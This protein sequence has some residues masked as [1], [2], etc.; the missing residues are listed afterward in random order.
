MTSYVYDPN[1][2]IEIKRLHERE[3]RTSVR[4]SIALEGVEIKKGS[5]ILDVGS[6]TGVL[7]FDLLTR[8]EDGS[9]CCI[10]LE[11]S[12]LV[13]ADENKPSSGQSYFVA[14]DAKRLPFDEGEFDVVACQYLLQHL[15]D[16]SV[17]LSEMRRVA[18]KD[19]LA[20][21]F[22]WDDGVNFTYPAPPEE[23][24][25]VLKAKIK[26]IH[27]RGGDRNIGRRLYHL[28]SSAGWSDVEIRIIHDIWQG[29]GDRSAALLG[30]ELSLRELKPQLLEDGSISEEAFEL[31]I[32]QLYDFYCGDIFSVVF[33]FAAFARNTGK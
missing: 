21:V 8:I 5:S 20:I 13:R 26:L 23:M 11:P 16:L 30:T 25:R 15:T 3:K 9:L 7:G 18:K 2:F 22:E 31:A 33:F 10:D 19:A 17:S 12:I 24:D 4:R 32:E 27:Q 29:P 14:S 1:S 28:L 6:G